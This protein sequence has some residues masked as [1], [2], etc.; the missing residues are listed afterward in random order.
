M[1]TGTGQKR[2]LD[3]ALGSFSECWLVWPCRWLYCT[4]KLVSVKL[5][6]G[7]V[8][9]KELWLLH[10]AVAVKSALGTG[11]CIGHLQSMLHWALGVGWFGLALG[12]IVLKIWFALG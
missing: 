12:F 7:S 6:W 8:G 11:C 9:R 4:K 10:W 1:G 2:A 5:H 3:V